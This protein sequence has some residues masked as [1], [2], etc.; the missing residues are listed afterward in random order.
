MSISPHPQ[1]QQLLLTLLVFVILV[2]ENDSIILCIFKMVSEFV[3]HIYIQ[4]SS[5]DSICIRTLS[6]VVFYHLS[7]DL[8]DDILSFLD[9]CWALW[10][11]VKRTLPSLKF[12]SVFSYHIIHFK[13]ILRERLGRNSSLCSNNQLTSCSNTIY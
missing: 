1:Q 3:H 7:F 5:L 12:L 8:V 2:G 10:E 11:A 13:L 9:A 6:G 4:Q